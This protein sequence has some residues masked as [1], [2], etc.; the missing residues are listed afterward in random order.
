M[1]A[2]L[3]VPLNAPLNY[4][5]LCVL[6][7]SRVRKLVY[8]NT[9]APLTLLTFLGG[10]GSCTTQPR[11]GS[12]HVR[13]DGKETSRPSGG[14]THVDWEETREEVCNL[15]REETW[16]SGGGTHWARMLE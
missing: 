9:Y 13:P 11:C 5:S 14:G 12:L 15:H 8:V 10:P 3:V 4:C 6:L 16:P 2:V 1:T 7:P